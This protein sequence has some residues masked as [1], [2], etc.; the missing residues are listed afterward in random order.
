[1]FELRELGAE[2]AEIKAAE[3]AIDSKLRR[4]RFK[5][6]IEYLGNG[7]TIKTYSLIIKDININ[8]RHTD[9]LRTVYKSKWNNIELAG[10][11]INVFATSTADISF[12]TFVI[13]EH[14]ITMYDHVKSYTNKIFLEGRQY[15]AAENS[16]IID[17]NIKDIED[18]EMLVSAALDKNTHGLFKTYINGG[19]TRFY[20]LRIGETNLSKE[21]I[22]RL[23]ARY[24]SKEWESS[25]IAGEPT[26]YYTT[27]VQ[28]TYHL[29]IVSVQDS[30]WGYIVNLFNRTFKE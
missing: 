19:I 7:N 25:K 9:V 17:T 27:K 2:D 6:H 24:K 16:N 26:G 3:K 5:V 18:I 30:I 12:V 13:K 10:E 4:K 8:R 11:V 20:T 21:Q 1:M 28:D 15:N 23:S 22:D 14:K 29:N